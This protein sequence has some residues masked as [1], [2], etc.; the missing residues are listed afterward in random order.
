MGQ[1]KG[2]A[3]LQG[4]GHSIKV[5]EAA[6]TAAELAET[7]AADAKAAMDQARVALMAID[8]AIAACA[9]SSIGSPLGHAR[10]EAEVAVQ[11][12][13]PR[14]LHS[15]NQPLHCLIRSPRLDVHSTKPRTA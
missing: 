5:A 15:H 2:T 14:C 11:V 12:P 6:C 1:G 4:E 13:P 8:T 7:A 3:R 10:A 9:G